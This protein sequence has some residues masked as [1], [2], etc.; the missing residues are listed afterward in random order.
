MI[1]LEGGG[2]FLS[3]VGFKERSFLL[4]LNP[5]FETLGFYWTIER[6]GGEPFPSLNAS[7]AFSIKECVKHLNIFRNTNIK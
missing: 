1:F 6:G 5:L 4:G 2:C 7:V 3:R